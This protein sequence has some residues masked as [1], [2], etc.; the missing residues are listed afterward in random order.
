MTYVFFSYY[1]SSYLQIF[2]RYHPPFWGGRKYLAELHNKEFTEVFEE[3]YAYLASSE[4]YVQYVYDEYC[5]TLDRAV[6]GGNLVLVEYTRKD[7]TTKSFILNYGAYD[8]TVV[9]GG[10]EY[11]VAAN[12]FTVVGQ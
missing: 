6:T 11:S 3:T 1:I 12:G 4:T 10:T 9:V 8:A 2:H 5:A 7:G